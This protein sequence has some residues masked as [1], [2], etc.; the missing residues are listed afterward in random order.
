MADKKKE[1]GVVAGAKNLSNK[2]YISEYG[3]E[4]R[5]AATPTGE[6]P[7]YLKAIAP[8]IKKV[9][10]FPVRQVGVA[11]GAVGVVGSGLFGTEN[12]YADM[13]KSYDSIYRGLGGTPQPVSQI[14]KPK[15]TVQ[16]QG[17]APAAVPKPTEFPAVG[18]GNPAPPP[19]TGVAPLTRDQQINEFERGMA[20]NFPGFGS[21]IGNMDTLRNTDTPTV[22]QY[23]YKDSKGVVNTFT[24]AEELHAAESQDL[25]AKG[26][27]KGNTTIVA[28][29]VSALSKEAFEDPEKKAWAEG[30]RY[31]ANSPSS[32]TAANVRD[33]MVKRG[34][35][36][37]IADIESKKL[38]LEIDKAKQEKEYKSPK[39]KADFI[40]KLLKTPR[41]DA[42]GQP[43]GSYTIED[44]EEIWRVGVLGEPTKKTGMPK[45]GTSEFEL[46]SESIFDEALSVY[47]SSPSKE[48]AG[49]IAK[50]LTK[51]GVSLDYVKNLDIVK[52]NPKFGK[53]IVEA[54]KKESEPF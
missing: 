17:A 43:I 28:R 38:E 13:L 18:G 20:K 21:K 39:N 5:G 10:D 51:A 49:S 3:I 14:E 48:T 2:P 11:A 24:S 15:V 12:S 44:A 34:T 54:M 40:A 8:Y 16:A 25:D 50:K 41:T 30:V 4:D 6:T 9:V 29:G 22:F 52:N 53:A 32:H 42:L 36:A 33:L 35:E 31:A 26:K 47:K 45:F 27:P 37:R 7:P 19:A 23:Q 46:E 1:Q